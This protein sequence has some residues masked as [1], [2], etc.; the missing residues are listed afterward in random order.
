MQVLIIDD[1]KLLVKGLRKSLEQEGFHVSV[2]HDGGEAWEIFQR[3][4][5][6]FI[7]LDLMLPKIDGISLCRMMREK[8]EVPIIMLTAKDSDI[9]KILGL[10]LGADDYITK[11]FNTRELIAR[12][13]AI[14]RRLEKQQK[15][16]GKKATF[17]VSGNLEV[18]LIS[19][20]VKLGEKEIELTPKE[21]DILEFLMANRGQVFS[22]EQIFQFIWNEPC[23]DTRTIDVHIKNLREKLKEDQEN[24]PFIQTKWGVGYYFRRD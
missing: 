9:D 15:D 3:G 17:Y 19:R 14:T 2:A 22:R 24:K 10:E 7:I 11:P 23:Y 16:I 20:V 5:F 6:D 4:T 1:E 12:M 21:F 8:S 13:R 18:D